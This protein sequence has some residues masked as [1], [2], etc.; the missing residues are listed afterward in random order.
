MNI[1]CKKRMKR[2][3]VR[4]HIEG[5]C[6]GR[7]EGFVLQRHQDEMNADFATSLAFGQVLSQYPLNV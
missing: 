5:K 2:I 4:V 7:G 6:N 3:D 1:G